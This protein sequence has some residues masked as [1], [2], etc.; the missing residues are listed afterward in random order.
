MLQVKKKN[1][2][3]KPEIMKTINNL[4]LIAFAIALFAACEKDN[5]CVNGSGSTVS[6]DFSIANFDELYLYG[7]AE[8]IITKASQISLRIEGQENV[9]N[10]LNVEVKNGDLSI[11]RDNCFK[12]SRELKVYLS[13]PTLQGVKV[14]G[15]CD[16]STNGIFSGASFRAEIDGAGSMDL[17]LD[18]QEFNAYISGDGEIVADGKA[19]S[20]TITIS[21]MGEMQLFDLKGVMGDISIDGSG[22]I[23]IYENNT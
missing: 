14:S 16:I 23:E 5:N 1:S 11:G 3:Q 20:Q 15:L 17:Q 8:V 4:M 13:T 22:E 12:D 19:D 10:A 6:K 18:V 2:I 7:D 9:L 21:G